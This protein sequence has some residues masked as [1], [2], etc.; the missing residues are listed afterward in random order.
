MSLNHLI[1]RTPDEAFLGVE[2]D[3]RR[4]PIIEAWRED[5][6]IVWVRADG[7]EERVDLAGARDGDAVL[8]AFSARRGLMVVQCGGLALDGETFAQAITQSSAGR[9]LIVR[10]RLV[11][12]RERLGASSARL[13]DTPGGGT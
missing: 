7:V 2:F 12:L 9:V 1:V 3:D 5:E 6:H 8:E 13:D 4:A 10:D 11:E